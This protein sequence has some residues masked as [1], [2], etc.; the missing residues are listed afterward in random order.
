MLKDQFG[1]IGQ[2]MTLRAASTDPS[3]VE[4]SIGLDLTALGMDMN[5]PG[6]NYP[7]FGG[8]FKHFRLQPHE[9]EHQVPSEYIIHDKIK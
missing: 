7:L 4:L 1:I 2:I 3:L 8:P 6:N 5:S 9:I